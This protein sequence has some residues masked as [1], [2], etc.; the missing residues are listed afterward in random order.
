[1][2]KAEL[3]MVRQRL[4]L[5]ASTVVCI[6]VSLQPTLGVSAQTLVESSE[7]SAQDQS[8]REYRIKARDLLD[9][10]IEGV[11]IFNPSREVNDRGKIRIFLIGEIQAE[12]ATVKELEAEIASRLNE[13]LIDPKIR[14]RVRERRTTLH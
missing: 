9:I 5:L 10:S 4:L 11:C 14:I 1:M 13:Y 8:D 7:P 3:R 2:M 6:V 12:G